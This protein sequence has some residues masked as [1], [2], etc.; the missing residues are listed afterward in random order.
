MKEKEITELKTVEDIQR[1][2]GITYD[3]ELRHFNQTIQKYD[4]DYQIFR[5]KCIKKAINDKDVEDIRRQGKVL[6]ASH[7]NAN[8]HDD[9]TPYNDQG[10][11][12]HIRERRERYIKLIN[13]LIGT[14]PQNKG[15]KD[16]NKKPILGNRLTDAQIEKLAILANDVNIFED[17]IC[18]DILKNVLQCT[19][20][21]PL[22]LRSTQL[23]SCFLNELAPKYINENWQSSVE[24][25]QLFKGSKGALITAKNLSASL[26]NLNRQSSEAKKIIHRIQLLS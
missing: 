24:S 21:K 9:H 7:E 8:I 23:L 4:K 17:P 18:K 13:N 10:L 25:H 22:K 5:E 6:V 14:L 16:N 20:K 11:N 3:Q 26:S 19:I 15:N 1:A 2:F 12:E